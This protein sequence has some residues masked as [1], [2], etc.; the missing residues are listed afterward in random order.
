MR[1][2]RVS[3]LGGAVAHAF[4]GADGGPVADPAVR[5]AVTAT[6]LAAAAR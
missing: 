4:H 6:V 2:I 3:T 1:Y 5:R